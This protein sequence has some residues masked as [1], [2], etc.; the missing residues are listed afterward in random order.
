[1]NAMTQISP[2][3]LPIAVEDGVSAL[4]EPSYLSRRYGLDGF[5]FLRTRENRF[6]FCNNPTFNKTTC[7]TL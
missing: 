2:N 5:R 4:T 1:M 7:K 6:F 3:R